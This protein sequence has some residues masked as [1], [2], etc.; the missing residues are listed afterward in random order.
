VQRDCQCAEPGPVLARCAPVL[1]RSWADVGVRYGARRGR[2]EKHF[3]AMP[4]LTVEGM[5]NLVEEWVRTG[6]R[7]DTQ[8]MQVQW[9]AAPHVIAAQAAPLPV[10]LRT[11]PRSAP[12]HTHVSAHSSAHMVAHARA[13]PHALRQAQRCSCD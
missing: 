13:N 11:M 9:P 10:A 8:A 12:H 1:G 5:L 2:H 7:P 4:D 3:K 6:G